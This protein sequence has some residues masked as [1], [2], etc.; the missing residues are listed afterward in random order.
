[1]RRPTGV[2]ARLQVNG[3]V[4]MLAFDMQRLQHLGGETQ[5][6]SPG[7]SSSSDR[8]EIVISGGAN[9]LTIDSDQAVTGLVRGPHDPSESVPLQ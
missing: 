3:E 9:Q 8:Y 5:L 2:A 6:E 1:L 7:Y 4:N